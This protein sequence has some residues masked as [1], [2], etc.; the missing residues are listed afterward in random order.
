MSRIAG[1]FIC[2]LAAAA[3]VAL[4]WG[5]SVRSY[6]AIAVPVALAALGFLALIFWIG[7]TLLT[8]EWAAPP[9]S[10][11]RKDGCE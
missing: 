9:P 1:L 8:G 5:L 3:V 10:P 2:A 11:A 4:V 6:W 7:L